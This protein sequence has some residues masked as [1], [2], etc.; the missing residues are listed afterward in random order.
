M[1]DIKDSP[2]VDA[3]LKQEIEKP[4]ELKHVE[5]STQYHLKIYAFNYTYSINFVN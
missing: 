3:S 2:K 5:V 4:T 1:A